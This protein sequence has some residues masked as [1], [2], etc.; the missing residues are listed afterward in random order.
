MIVSHDATSFQMI[1]VNI[2]SYTYTTWLN[3]C[4]GFSVVLVVV[5][6]SQPDTFLGVFYYGHLEGQIEE[7]GVAKAQLPAI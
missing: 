7:W 1:L 3:L 4:P 6:I 2:R 5:E